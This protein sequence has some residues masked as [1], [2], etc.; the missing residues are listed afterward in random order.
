VGRRLLVVAAVIAVFVVI[1]IGYAEAS[2]FGTSDLVRFEADSGIDLPDWYGSQPW[3]ITGLRADGQAF[4]G[5]AA[6][7]FAVGDVAERVVWPVMRYSRIGYSLAAWLVSVGNTALI[8]IALVL[9]SI[10][11]V[12]ALTWIADR[13]RPRV[14]IRAWLLVANP[15]VLIGFVYG[16]AEP[17]ALALLALAF[18]GGLGWAAALGITRPSFLVALWGRWRALIAALV[19]AVAVRVWASWVFGASATD[20]TFNFTWPFAGYYGSAWFLA[21]FAVGVAVVGGMQRRWS[22]VVGGLFVLCFGPTI[23]AAGSGWRVSGFLWVLL[24]LDS[25]D[26]EPGG[27]DPDSRGLNGDESEVPSYSSRV[28]KATNR[29]AL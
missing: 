2:G 27:R 4:V 10:A 25:K 8:P 15:A 5:L 9:V 7:P 1:R 6:D 12:A 3:L 23:H 18:V 28:P 29:P 19:A 26:L 24:A 13:V 16:T 17:F 14:G 20:G 21:L 22:W 11:S